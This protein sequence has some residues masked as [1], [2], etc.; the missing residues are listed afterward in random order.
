MNFLV[1]CTNAKKRPAD[2]PIEKWIVEEQIYT[3]VERLEMV[4]Q[5]MAIGYVLKE[6]DLSS[7]K[8]YKAFHSK[9][10]RLATRVD[11]ELHNLMQEVIEEQNEVTELV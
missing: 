5:N 11:L 9:R 1:V 2:F 4:R 3:V 6:I 7:V 8:N 10:F